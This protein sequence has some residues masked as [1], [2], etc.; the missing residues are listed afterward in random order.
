MGS[1]RRQGP[2]PARRRSTALEQAV[3]SRLSNRAGCGKQAAGSAIGLPRS[4]PD[5]LRGV[6]QPI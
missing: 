1:D 2:L 4:A 3:S 6:P 5:R